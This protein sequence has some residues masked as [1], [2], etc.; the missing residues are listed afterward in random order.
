MR[1]VCFYKFKLRKLIFMI[2]LTI[3][4]M[5][6]VNNIKLK[7]QNIQKLNTHEV[8]YRFSVFAINNETV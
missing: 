4:Q 5:I 7:K 8:H 2:D 3:G 6:K 1:T